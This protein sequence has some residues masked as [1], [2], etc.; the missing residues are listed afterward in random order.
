MSE[1][2]KTMKSKGQESGGNAGQ[3]AGTGH[4]GSAGHTG[5]DGQ[6]GQAG[7]GYQSGQGTH[8]AAGAAAGLM[9]SAKSTASQVVDSARD[10]ASVVA[11]EGREAASYLGHMAE[12]ATSAVAGGLK[13]AGQSLR[14]RLPNEGPL[15]TA[16]T[17]VA[18][19][20]EGSGDYLQQ[21]GLKGMGDDLTQMV[22]NNPLP[23]LFVGVGI[24]YLLAQATSSRR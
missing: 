13:S 19:S 9:D 18:R 24:G 3:S 22:K 8:T 10:A 14:E 20:L 6:G 23:S 11:R 12:D 4:S 16:S 5:Q 7:Q 21:G 2:W 15:G 17:A 1:A